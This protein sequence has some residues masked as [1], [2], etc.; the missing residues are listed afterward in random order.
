MY[1]AEGKVIGVL[2]IGSIRVSSEA[3]GAPLGLTDLS[4]RKAVKFKLIK[5][6]V[7]V[8]V[9]AKSDR[10]GKEMAVGDESA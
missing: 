9:M 8:L 1:R 7:T 3:R 6:L 4:R 10:R 5:C 2:M